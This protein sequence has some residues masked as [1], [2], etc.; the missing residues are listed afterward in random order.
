MAK[1]TKKQRIEFLKK[2]AV[3]LYGANFPLREIAKKLKKSHSWVWL[4]VKENEQKLDK[5]A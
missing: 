1:G 5:V 2:E 4:A 3:A